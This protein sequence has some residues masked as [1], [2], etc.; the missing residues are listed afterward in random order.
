MYLSF[1]HNDRNCDTGKAC[2]HTMSRNK[3]FDSTS[4]DRTDSDITG[5]TKSESRT[6]D[7]LAPGCHAIVTA[8]LSSGGM[9]RRLL[10]MGLTPGTQ[11]DCL[12]KSPLG[13]PTAFLIRGAVIALRRTD[14]RD[15]LIEDSRQEN[16]SAADTEVLI[17]NEVQEE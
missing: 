12:G 10:D 7:D 8:L 5:C 1:C 4:M 3:T 17:Q 13:D 2:L 14:C 11:V 9:R 6:L 15:I 16:L